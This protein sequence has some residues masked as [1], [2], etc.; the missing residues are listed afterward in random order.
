MGVGSQHHTLAD[1]PREMR[2][3]THHTADW[4]GPRASL[5]KFE[6]SHIHQ[7]DKL[8]MP[9]LNMATNPT[10]LSDL[11]SI[12]QK[13]NVTKIEAHAY[14]TAQRDPVGQ[15]SSKICRILNLLWILLDCMTFF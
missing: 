5:N 15:G 3:G 14:P 8:L 1:L 9:K 6:R 13:I 10:V 2:F 7:D 12:S 11:K 4:V